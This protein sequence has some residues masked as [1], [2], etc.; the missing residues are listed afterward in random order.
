MRYH[1]RSRSLSVT[2]SATV[3]E[4]RVVAEAFASSFPARIE[5]SGRHIGY[6]RVVAF[7]LIG[8]ECAADTP[9]ALGAPF[10]SR[11]PR[12]SRPRPS[13][14]SPLGTQAV[15]R[16]LARGMRRSQ[17]EQMLH[18]GSLQR[19]PIGFHDVDPGDVEA[20]RR[21]VG[22]ADL[23]VG[24]DRRARKHTRQRAM[25]QE[26]RRSIRRQAGES[27]TSRL[28]WSGRGARCRP[29]RTHSGRRR[30]RR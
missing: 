25:R 24:R 30:T 19:R 21:L 1:A 20:D 3:R 27:A 5:R 15:A 18:I 28:N 4:W 26:Q 14:S 16:P 10:R 13:P 6:Y 22:E 11:T 29:R 12:Q 9:G 17:G 2:S 8:G 7:R 23:R